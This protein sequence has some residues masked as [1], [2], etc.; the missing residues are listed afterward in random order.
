MRWKFLPSKHVL[1]KKVDNQWPE[2]LKKL[3][4]ERPN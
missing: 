2:Y 3:E 4:K 1:E